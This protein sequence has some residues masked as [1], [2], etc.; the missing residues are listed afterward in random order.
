MTGQG[1]EPSPAP[2][3]WQLRFR[4]RLRDHEDVRETRDPGA[5]DLPDRFQLVRVLGQGGMGEVLLAYDRERGEQVALKSLHGKPGLE[6]KARFD[7]ES[8]ILS[9]LDHP[10][11]VD[12]HE[13]V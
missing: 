6:T 12:V 4:D 1:P 11:V 3:G 5:I 2:N 13:L 9:K 8:Q 10:H 7:R